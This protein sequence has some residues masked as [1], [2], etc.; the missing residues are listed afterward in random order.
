MYLWLVCDDC[1]IWCVWS[2]GKASTQQP[3]HT[4]THPLVYM[5]GSLG[6]YP[7]LR[8]EPDVGGPKG[9]LVNVHR[10][11]WQQWAK[12]LGTLATLAT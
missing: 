2:Q 5:G 8:L 3:Q 11:W 4:H 12:K 1:K 6:S 9:R 10:L 7:R